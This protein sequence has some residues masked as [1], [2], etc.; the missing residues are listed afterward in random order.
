MDGETQRLDAVST[1]EALIRIEREF[2]GWMTWYGAD[3][4]CHALLRSGP[5]LTVRGEDPVD[6]RDQIIRAQAFQEGL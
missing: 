2:P 5:I 6:L 3:Q 1:D 4:M